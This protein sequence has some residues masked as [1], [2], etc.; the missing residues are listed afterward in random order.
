MH[1]G[2]D[3]SQDGQPDP[4]VTSA[5]TW[6]CLKSE[7]ICM[8]DAAVRQVGHAARLYQPSSTHVAKSGASPNLS[9]CTACAMAMPTAER[10][11]CRMNSQ[12]DS[13]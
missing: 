12:L 4:A 5:R 11:A 9:M 3:H 2:A 6:G 13:K 1:P 10:L 7:D 8:L